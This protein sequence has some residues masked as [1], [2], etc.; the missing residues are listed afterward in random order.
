VPKIQDVYLDF[1][2]EPGDP[3]LAHAI[4]MILLSNDQ[5][6]Q[7]SLKSKVNNQRFAYMQNS[8]AVQR[9]W[10]D[11]ERVFWQGGARL[12][13]NEILEMLVEPSLTVGGDG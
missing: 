1:D 8:T 3:W 12:S 6:V 7:V 9:P 11:G 4:L 5:S 13:F 10:T 2:D